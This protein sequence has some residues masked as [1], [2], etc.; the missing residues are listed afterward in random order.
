MKTIEA[1]HALGNEFHDQLGISK[2]ISLAS[3][4]SSR[5]LVKN[6]DLFLRFRA[7]LVFE[8]DVDHFTRLGIVDAREKSRAI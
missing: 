7:L 6:S 1:V 5:R 2:E 4:N 8:P 3:N